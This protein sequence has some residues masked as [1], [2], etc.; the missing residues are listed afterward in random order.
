[1]KHPSSDQSLSL[2]IIHSGK[3]G[4]L[5]RS[6]SCSSCSGSKS[7]SRSKAQCSGKKFSLR[8]RSRTRSL[9][10]PCCGS[11]PQRPFIPTEIL[12][13]IFQLGA[14]LDSEFPIILS[15]VCADWRCIVL[16]CPFLWTRLRPDGRYTLFSTMI[17]RSGKLPVDINLVLGREFRGSTL[18]SDAAHMRLSAVVNGIGRWRSLS[19][20][21]DRYSPYFWNTALSILCAK[22][23]QSLTITPRLEAL[24]LIFPYNDDSKEYLLFGNSSPKLQHVV[25]CGIRLKW[26]SLLFGNLVTLDYTHHGFSRGREAA[27]EILSMLHV[28]RA[29]LK[30]LTVMFPCK[31]DS[32]YYTD[33]W[34]ADLP[35]VELRQL[36]TLV[37]KA[38]GFH[39][40]QL[41]LLA[42]LPHVRLPYLQRLVLTVSSA[43]VVL[44]RNAIRGVCRVFYGHRTLQIVKIDNVW[45]NEQYSPPLLHSL[46]NLQTVL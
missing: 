17:H 20:R 40:A 21:C 2:V 8:R 23:T 33:N 42:F 14:Q 16:Q 22:P 12:V 24:S 45:W 46:P 1:M 25:L 37:L 11:R 19:I 18:A 30:H 32:A 39:A 10:S 34:F 6:P 28:S 27:L 43:S 31:T 9:T 5:P 15:Q 13:R 44:A 38:N 36:E 41:E 7:K 29:R 26:T 3:A 4:S 35:V